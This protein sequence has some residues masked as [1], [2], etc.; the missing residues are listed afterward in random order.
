MDF[1]RI[2]EKLIS[3]QKIETMVE[4]I[5]RLRSEGF[6]QQ[7]VAQRLNVD[8]TF[9]SRL[10]GI[11]EV[12]KGSRV[13]VVGFPIQNTEEITAVL[14]EAG[15]DYQLIWT[16]AQRQQFIRDKDGPQLLA[17][18][19]QKVTEVRE[20]DVVVILGSQYRIRVT[21]AMLDRE[22]VGMVIGETPITE[23]VYVDPGELRQLLQ[24]LVRAKRK[25]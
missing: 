20:Y 15:V 6:S 1:F 8:R 7:E 5:L 22:V 10:E 18:F 24:N 23:D 3:K 4:K 19:L 2:G 25:P 9:I 11:G 21:E 12:R 16:E 17:D 13:A 14:K